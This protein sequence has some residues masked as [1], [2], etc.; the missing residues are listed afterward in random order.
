MKNFI[1][2]AATLLAIQFSMS[3]YYTYEFDKAFIKCGTEE[4]H[5]GAKPERFNCVYKRLGHLDLAA[6]IILL[7]PV[8][9]YYNKDMGWRY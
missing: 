4:G 1:L 3:A 2:G 6:R 8:Y 5:W 7:R 9:D